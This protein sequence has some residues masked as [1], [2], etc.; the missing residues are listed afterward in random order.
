MK[1]A[2]CLI[3]KIA[4]Y[5]N[6]Y[7]A[8]Y[9]AK[10]GKQA[11]TDVLE[12][13][14]DLDHKLKTM[15]QKLAAGNVD[16][17]NYTYFKIKDPKER[18]ICAASF[19]ER[20]LHHAIMNICHPYFERQLIYDT[21]ATRPGKGTYAALGRARGFVK[22]YEF[23]AKLD[24]SKHF[25]NISHCILKEKLARIFK[26]GVLLS[27]FSKIIDSYHVTPKMGL[28][29]GNL[30]SQY[31]AN[32]YFS[33]ADHFA[34]E[35]LKMKAYLRYMDDILIF[36]SDKALLKT[37]LQEF[38]EYVTRELNFVFKPV[39][40]GNTARGVVFLG[41]KLYPS[42]VRL[43]RNSKK[44]FVTKIKQYHY[45]LEKGIWTQAEY[46]RHV[47]PLLAFAKYANSDGLIRKYI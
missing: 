31:F 19:H 29:I 33:C 23:Y 13:E 40:S 26:D 14:K 28:P 37:K 10:K 35:K 20:V 11:K 17:G 25:D 9:K 30:T 43:N 34:K 3:E 8:Y 6:L 46:Q 18:V 2:A 15:Q 5:D 7:L 22:K 36:S 21:Y 41:Y 32:Y 47:L 24:V 16:V 1:R 27:V 45:N 44:R 12:Y 38:S 39:V 4:A 42:F